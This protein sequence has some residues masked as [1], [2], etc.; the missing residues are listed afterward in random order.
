MK[1]ATLTQTLSSTM[2]RP[3]TSIVGFAMFFRFCED[4]QVVASL[5][6][7]FSRFR[8]LRRRN[9]VV[10]LVTFEGGGGR[11]PDT[12]SRAVRP[13]PSRSSKAEGARGPPPSPT[14]QVG[15]L[16]DDSRVAARPCRAIAGLRHRRTTLHDGLAG[17]LLLLVDEGARS[18]YE[19]VTRADARSLCFCRGRA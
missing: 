11:R 15:E 18:F 13:S 19:G 4:G 14:R 8:D 2:K 3:R 6:A 5:S 7:A 16:L 1:V 17:E 10:A 9:R 12:P